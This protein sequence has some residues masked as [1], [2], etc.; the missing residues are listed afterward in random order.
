MITWFLP[1]IGHVGI[2]P[3]NGKIHDFAGSEYIGINNFAFGRTRKYVKLKLK[4]SEVARFDECVSKADAEYRTRDHNIF[5]DNCHS[6][7]AYALNQFAYQG[8]K[9]HTMVTLW[10]QLCTESKY[11]SWTAV[12]VTY[13]P[14]LLVTVLLV[15]LIVFLSQIWIRFY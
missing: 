13:L 2:A 1:C 7:A 12:I 14:C 3:S 9:K 11:V 8:S 6:H 4:E 5:C 10:W 15:G